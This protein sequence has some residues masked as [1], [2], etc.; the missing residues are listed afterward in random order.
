VIAS[1]LVRR[2]S[3]LIAGIESPAR[4][5]LVRALG[6]LARTLRAARGGIV[7]IGLEACIAYL[8]VHGK[9]IGAAHF[10]EDERAGEYDLS[11]NGG[12]W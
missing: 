12:E 11:D 9:A 6:L 3:L 8:R 5:A 7:I 2:P 10:A 4:S 1:C